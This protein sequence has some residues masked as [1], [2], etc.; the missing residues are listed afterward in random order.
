MNNKTDILKWGTDC[1][2]ANGYPIDRPH[3]IVL[4]T[5]WSTMIRFSTTTGD[6]Y[7]KQTP[8]AISAEP[9]IIQLLFEQFHASV[10]IVIASNEDLHCFLMHDAGKTLRVNLKEKFNP[11]LLCQAIKEYSALQRSTEDQL[12]KF[13]KLGV[14]D[15]RLDKLPTLYDHILSQTDFLKADSMTDQELQTLYDLRPQFLAQCEL[16]AS[17]GIPAT[18]GIPD[19]ND[20]NTLF[21]PNTGKM[22]FIDWGEAAIT[23]PFFSL[24]NCLDQAVKR[25]GVQEADQTYNKLVDACHENWLGLA[26]KD[27]LLEVF[28]STMQLRAIYSVLGCHRLMVSVDLQVLNDFYAST[29]PNRLAFAF[30][31]YINSCG[32]T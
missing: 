15:W 2:V 8:P 22:T 16:L 6:F 27:K 3:E 24:Y 23:H 32:K 29:Q 12:E 26:T 19:F 9:Q 20:N 18:I 17:Y 14:P 25:H 31:K 11:D 7:L 10:P 1:L 21:D 4:S 28:D 30:R 13:I 5:P